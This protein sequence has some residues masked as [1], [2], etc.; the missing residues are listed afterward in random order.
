[1]TIAFIPHRNRIKSNSNINLGTRYTPMEYQIIR[2]GDSRSFP[3][4]HPLTA[5]GK[6]SGEVVVI[7]GT[8]AGAAFQKFGETKRK[9]A[10]SRC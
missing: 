7:V 10:V 4:E 5:G 3:E 9:A 1:M 6:D 8:D 2:A